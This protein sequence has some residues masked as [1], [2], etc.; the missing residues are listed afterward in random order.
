MKS[1][2]ILQRILIYSHMYL[3]LNA[4]DAQFVQAILLDK[5]VELIERCEEELSRADFNAAAYNNA[6]MSSRRLAR[7]LEQFEP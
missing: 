5:Q 1:F 7:I 6:D 3:H 2:V 4:S